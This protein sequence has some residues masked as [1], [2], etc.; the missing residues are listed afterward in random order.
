[1][2]Q[3]S[4]FDLVAL[5]WTPAR[6]EAFVPFSAQG[7]V[8]AR[9]AA[10][11]REAYRVF[12]A[13]GEA[14]AEV[15]GALRHAATSAADFP[16]TGDWVALRPP[17]TEGPA[18]VRAVLPRTSR[19]S[20]KTA[21]AGTEE[22]IVAA[23]IDAVFLV[24]GLDGD[25]NLRRIER[26]LV[27]AW[28]SGASPVVVLSKADVCDDVAGRRAAVEAVAPG[29]PVL[30]V[31]ARAAEGLDALAPYLVPARTVALLGSSGVG[32]STL[33]NHLLGSDRQATRDVRVHDSRGRHT[34]THRELILLPCGALVV[35]TPGMRELQLWADDAG[36]VDAFEDVEALASACGFRDC[37]H[38]REP[39]CAVRRAVEEG[40]L[41]GGR[42]ESFF[43]LGREV[44][45][46]ELRRDQAAQAAEKKKLKAF[47]RAARDHTPRD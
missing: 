15:S 6:A 44:K 29:V 16:V 46:L 2:S 5:G 23:N 13:E 35:D 26:S 24:T 27:L 25:F 18:L 30:I 32:K 33:I 45:H 1:M 34:T 21:G 14:Q 31:S 3:G 12:S 36:V 38:E 41:E 10:V 20:R 8:P 28:E 42:L 22:Q 37:R 9:I 43:K 39:R 7:L 17:P 19:F 4:G 40:R 11:H 47:W